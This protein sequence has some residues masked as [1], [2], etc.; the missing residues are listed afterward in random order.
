MI[1]FDVIYD[2]LSPQEKLDFIFSFIMV[3]LTLSMYFMLTKIY[4]S[5]TDVEHMI[6]MSEI[7]IVIC[8]IFS[9]TC[10]LIDIRIHFF[11][12]FLSFL[13]LDICFKIYNLIFNPKIEYDPTDYS[14][15]G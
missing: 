4:L 12:A 1:N 9:Y 14:P 6:R 10:C 15:F 7:A 2:K 11:I 5:K 13:V 3:L 8:L